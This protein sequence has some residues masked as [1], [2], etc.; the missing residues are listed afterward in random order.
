MFISN[1]SGKMKRRIVELHQEVNGLLE[2][3]CMEKDRQLALCREQ[4]KSLW[5]G[6]EHQ[7]ENDDNGEVSLRLHKTSDVVRDE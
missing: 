1:P 7:M 5:D 3:E 6:S 4:I 2:E